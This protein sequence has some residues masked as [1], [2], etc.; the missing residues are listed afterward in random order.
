MKVRETTQAER[1][2]LRRVAYDVPSVGDMA[3]LAMSI[4][5]VMGTDISWSLRI[6]LMDALRAMHADY[7]DMIV[8]VAHTDIPMPTGV[9]YSART[10]PMPG[11]PA[12]RS[13]R[14]R[15]LAARAIEQGWTATRTSGGHVRIERGGFSFIVSATSSGQGRAWKNARALARRMGVD[16][17]GL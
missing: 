7:P 4:Q 13:D 12:F 17:D 5:A 15:A 2:L 6:R 10:A 1:D 16:V 14:F 9:T 11:V 8:R 3:S